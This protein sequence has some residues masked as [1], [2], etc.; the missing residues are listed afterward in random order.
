MSQKIFYGLRAEI[1]FKA[2]LKMKVLW[3]NC[4]EGTWCHV[5]ENYNKKFI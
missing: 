2:D 3:K 5:N 4:G 1:N